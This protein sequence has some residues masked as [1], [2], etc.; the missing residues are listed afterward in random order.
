MTLINLLSLE[1]PSFQLPRFPISIIQSPNTS[2]ICSI[3]I[4]IQK[5]TVTCSHHKLYFTSH[6]TRTTLAS[7]QLFYEV[8]TEKLFHLNT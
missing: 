7:E 5:A 6:R 8:Y 4:E 3:C 2:P 1:H